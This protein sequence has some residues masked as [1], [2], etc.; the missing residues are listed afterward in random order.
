MSNVNGGEKINS[1]SVRALKSSGIE[2]NFKAGWSAAFMGVLVLYLFTLAPG[3]VWQDQ[4]DYQLQA[5]RLSLNREGDVVRVHP[6]YILTAHVLGRFTPMDYALAANFVS[7]IFSAVAAANVYL[8]VLF[9]TK[10][11]WAAL[12][13][14]CLLCFSHTFWFVGVQAQSYSMSNAAMTGGVLLT[15]AYIDSGKTRYLY[16]MGLVFGLGISAHIMSQLAFGVIFIW[17]LSGYA[18]GR[19]GLGVILKV[20][21]SWAAGAF[22]LWLVIWIEYQRSGELGA[23]IGSAIWGRWGEAVFNFG[24]LGRLVKRSV[25]FFVLNFPTPLVLLSAAGIYL[26]SRKLWRLS[27]VRL[28]LVI[29][30]LYV[31]FAIRYDV[32]NQNHFFLPMYVMV[33]IYAGIGY[34]MMFSGRGKLWIIL[35]GV[36]ILLMPATYPLLARLAKERQFALGTRR[37]IP[38]RDVYNYYLIPWQQDQRGPRRFAEQV[39]DSLPENA[40]VFADSTTIPPLQY[41]HDIEQRR[42]DIDLTGTGGLRDEYRSVMESGRRL[43]T[44]SNV[45]GYYPNWV[46]S[47]DWLKPF[48]ISET[49]HIY[50][51]L[52]A[53]VTDKKEITN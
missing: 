9:L 49:E 37:P 20:A 10:H 50:E 26:S 23:T 8:I 18:R 1:G 40:W 42:P 6:L 29:T 22:L 30:I 7:A 41:V 16:L 4:G 12:L 43:F 2:A 28:L 53:A 39:F 25:L 48:S 38:Y 51:I 14:T 35:S 13:S 19:L 32:P 3:L 44:I 46:E 5:A 33:S 31:L 45:K 24:Q 15:T 17:M 52:P 36:M 27:I 11:R 34:A 47:K 21:A